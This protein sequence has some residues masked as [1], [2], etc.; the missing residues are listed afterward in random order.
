[1]YPIYSFF[2]L[3]LALASLEAGLT[4]NGLF[5]DN[6]LL[7]RNQAVPVWG[8]A[9]PGNCITVAFANQEKTA[10]ANETGEWQLE[11]DPMPASGIP[12]TMLISATPGGESIARSNILV[13]DV[14]LCG[15]QSNM[16]QT[17]DRY[18]IWDQV[19][20]DFSN[21]KLRLFK[22][23]EGGVGSPQPSNTLVIDKL[24]KDSWQ[25]CTPEYAAKFSATA[26]F[27]GMKLQHDTGVPI[28]LLY[29]NRGATEANMWL[30]REVLEANPDYARFLDPSNENWKPSKDNPDAIRAPSYLYNGTI[31]PL[32]PFAIRGAIWYQGESDSKL[33]GLYTSLFAN[34]I[35]S[36]RKLWG[37]QFPFYFV[38]LAPYSAVTADLS[39]ESW[40]W[41]RDAQLQCLE[42]VP[43]T[44]MAVITDAGEA[45]DI[46]PQAKD[47]PG[48][49]LAKLAASLDDRNI[50]ATFPVL[51]K[52]TTSRS[53]AYLTFKNV[54]GGL[55]TR[56]VAL[57]LSNGYLPGEAPDALVA[58]ELEGF[59]I[60]GEDRKF[61]KA[62]ALIVSNNEVMVFSP[63]VKKPVAVRYGWANFPICNLYGGNGMPA[64]PFRTD[65]FP[66][67]RFTQ[68]L[69]GEPFTGISD[70]WGEC[71]SILQPG[72]GPYL[73]VILDDIQCWS[74]DSNYLYFRSA[75]SGPRM[76]RINLLYYDEGYGN[77][78][79]LYD[80]TSEET[81][82][83]KQPG[84]WKPAGAIN[85]NN[86]KQWRVV[87]FDLPD[88]R[89]ERGCNGADFRIQSNGALIIGGVYAFSQ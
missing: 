76:S 52:M 43:N 39:G 8:N 23:K 68:Q 9:D 33:A 32:A 45:N 79:V 5:T 59:M 21:D 51:K 54:S 74:A 48:E 28:G 37:Y 17:M 88:A 72:D 86:S 16:A 44:G 42:L 58:V 41:L 34:V 46:H 63:S 49:R 70:D 19:K 73:Q 6:M 87:T 38:Q 26:G 20:D 77:M 40:A 27:F 30:P 22:L 83:S 25:V 60:C 80:S 53:K 81:Y 61:F 62:D 10:V 65:T 71:M 85:C 4:V 57:N 64:T 7:Q 82:A 2:I 67:P 14:W 31:F 78:Q 47:I 36:W 84:A 69:T 29:A 50:D 66:M 1:M 56:R 89:F 55:A 24:F 18:L 3:C 13:G 11:L 12:R 75:T 35:K 15:G